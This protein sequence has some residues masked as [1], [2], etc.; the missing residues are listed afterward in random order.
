MH[1]PFTLYEVDTKSI[2]KK[3]TPKID[4]SFGVYFVC[5]RQGS[6]KTYLAVKFASMLNLSNH[7]I[8]TNIH[9][10]KLPHDNFTKIDE[11]I[12]DTEEH[13]LYIIDE[14]SRKYPRNAPPDTQ[15]YAWLNQ[16]RKRK[17]VVILI[18]QEWKEVPMWLRRP[19]KIMIGCKP[20]AI[21]KLFG[22]CS[23]S[24]GDGEN[25]TFNKD[26]GEYEC[27]I[28]KKIIHKRNMEVAKLYDTFEP[29]NT[30]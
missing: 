30:L 20:T 14:I 1:I 25:M 5:G 22:F 24:W 8:K 23:E 19:C 10:L 2:F 29:I 26:E 17:R 27:P 13:V 15:F 18:T 28:F 6:G 4:D 7:T 16:S 11:I 12:H 3:R 21:L 9:S